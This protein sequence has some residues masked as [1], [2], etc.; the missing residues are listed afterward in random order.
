V[1]HLTPERLYE[2]ANKAAADAI[3]WREQNPIM[4]SMRALDAERLRRVARETLKASEAAT[5]QLAE[6]LERK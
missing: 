5:R 3:R 2:H 6:C 4:A 1:E